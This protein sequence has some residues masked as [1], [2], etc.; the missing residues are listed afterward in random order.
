MKK[1]LE[2]SV[3]YGQDWPLS[4]IYWEESD[5]PD[6][7]KLL[8][9]E[10]FTRLKAWAKFFSIHADEE[11]GMFGTEELRKWFDLE[12]VSIFNELKSQVGTQFELKINLWF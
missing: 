9:P 4:D 5:R 12:A 7:E 10:L 8:S 11:T 1:E 2:L 6:W 3:D